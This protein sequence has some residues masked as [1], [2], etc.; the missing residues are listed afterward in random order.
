M[1]Q[2]WWYALNQRSLAEEKNKGQKYKYTGDEEKCLNTDLL[3]TV[4]TIKERYKVM[5]KES[6]H[7]HH[8]DD[9]FRLSVLKDYYE[10]GCS[11]GE[12]AR[13]YDINS[14]NIIYWERKY[15][16]KCVPLPSDIHELEQ[17][18]I[19][20]KKTRKTNEDVH[21]QPLSEEERL[22]AENAR[23]RKALAYSELRNEA[24]HEVLKIGKEQ[25]GIDLLKKA[26]AKQ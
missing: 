6:R 1:F 22:K 5:K 8:F 14:G 20:A 2:K 16:N 23:L 3:Y 25:Y 26:G 11:Y 9:Q 10:S 21:P 13:K 19:M 7:R 15:M 12:I 17:Q 18:V 24:L 4:L